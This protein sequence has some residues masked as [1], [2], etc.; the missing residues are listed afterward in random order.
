[1]LPLDAYPFSERY[2]WIE[3]RYGV[4]WQ[5]VFAD[6]AE[7]RSIVP[8]LLFTGEVRGR[9]GSDGVRHC[10][11]RRFDGRGGHAVRARPATG[12]GRYRRARRFH[13]RR[14]GFAAMDGA[15][16]HD[17]TFTE[18]PSFLVDCADRAGVDSF[19]D[20]LPADGSMW[21]AGGQIRRLVADPPDGSR[22][23]PRG[24]RPRKSRTRRGGDAR[25]GETRRGRAGKCLRG[26]VRAVR[27]SRR[28]CPEA[29]R[30]G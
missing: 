11:I 25:D 26:R 1:M 10:D 2:G 27:R 6:G 28:S 18:A 15:R 14:Q 19:W 24:R 5:L 22:R 29:G 13:A 16:A 8:S 21:L 20:E 30:E 17:F 3:D 4:S 23:T 12:R 9:H 7:E